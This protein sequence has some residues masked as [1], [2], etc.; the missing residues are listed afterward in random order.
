[1]SRPPHR[2]VNKRDVKVLYKI[3]NKQ[4]DQPGHKCL[5]NKG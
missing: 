4:G 5:K 2:E 3:A 1:M